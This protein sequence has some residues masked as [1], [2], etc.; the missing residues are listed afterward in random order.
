MLHYFLGGTADDLLEHSPFKSTLA[1]MIEL[2]GERG[3]PLNLGGGVRPGDALDHFKQGFA[4][5]VAPFHTH[6]LICDPRAYEQLSAG[7]TNGGFFPL[8]RS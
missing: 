7:R 2:A 8:Y 1:A 5:A 3:L 4:N 6:E